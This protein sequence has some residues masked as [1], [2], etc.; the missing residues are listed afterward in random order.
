MINIKPVTILSGICC[1]AFEV[2]YHYML[3]TVAI[4]DEYVII[5]YIHETLKITCSFF[6]E[7]FM[8]KITK[9][10]VGSL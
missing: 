2:E 7:T 1:S 4:S 10:M 5:E 9:D 6:A 8:K 3:L